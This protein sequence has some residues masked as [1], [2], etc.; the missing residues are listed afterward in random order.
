MLRNA[1]FV[2]FLDCIPGTILN[3]HARK[4]SS[5]SALTDKSI[6]DEGMLTDDRTV[7]LIEVCHRSSG[8]HQ[9]KVWLSLFSTF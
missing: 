2:N 1:A 4:Y 8:G 6:E 9:G 3:E 5:K 7:F